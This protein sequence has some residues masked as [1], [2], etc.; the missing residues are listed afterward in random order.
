MG[1]VGF[2]SV[3]RGLERSVRAA[4]VG[5]TGWPA[6]T[7]REVS[8]ATRPASSRRSSWECAMRMPD[9]VATDRRWVRRLSWSLAPCAMASSAA[10]SAA[11]RSFAP[12]GAPLP[13][14][15]FNGL[16]RLRD[17]GLS[18]VAGMDARL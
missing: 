4:S 2:A 11:G 12:V 1:D 5:V 6:C 9:A 15:G 3:G 8:I 10:K 18:F 13:P 14:G 16:Q 7:G 17:A